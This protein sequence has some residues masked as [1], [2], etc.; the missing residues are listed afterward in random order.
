MWESDEARESA[1]DNA[2]ASAP[3][4]QLVRM[5]TTLWGRMGARAFL[6]SLKNLEGEGGGGSMISG[7]KRTC[8]PYLLT[9]SRSLA[10][11]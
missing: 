9:L 1:A 4:E 2:G 6:G 3:A 7:S 5:W 11:S 8:L 10:R